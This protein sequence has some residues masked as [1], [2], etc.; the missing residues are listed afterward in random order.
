MEE[1]RL[2]AV[3]GKI[4]GLYFLAAGVF[5]ISMGL[6]ELWGPITSFFSVS[7]SGWG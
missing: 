1:D 5:I 6:Y 2:N 4:F 3:V 7:G